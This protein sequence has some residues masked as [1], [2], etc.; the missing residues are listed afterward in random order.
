MYASQFKVH[1]VIFDVFAKLLLP[2]FNFTIF[3][4]PQNVDLC[5]GLYALCVSGS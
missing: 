2:F 5:A 4:R 3:Y 1:V